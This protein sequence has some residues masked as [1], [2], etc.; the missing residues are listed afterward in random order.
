MRRALREHE[1]TESFDGETTAADAADEV[2]HAAENKP[3]GAGR[4]GLWAM[5]VLA[6]T[7]HKTVFLPFRVGVTAAVT[8]KFVGWLAKRGWAGSQGTRRAA[9]H[10]RDKYGRNKEKRV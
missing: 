6:Y 10:V 5:A 7:I 2:Q 1:L 4:E 8:P 3:G 9:Q